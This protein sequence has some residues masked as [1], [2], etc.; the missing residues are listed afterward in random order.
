MEIKK[1]ALCLVSLVSTTTFAHLHEV[2]GVYPAHY[3][4]CEH[5]DFTKDNVEIAF[6]YLELLEAALKSAIEHPNSGYFRKQA[7]NSIVLFNNA[8]Y[9]LFDDRGS[10]FLL[11]DA[12]D[13]VSLK[14]EKF[15]E[16][17]EQKR[18]EQGLNTDGFSIGQLIRLWSD[19]DFVL[20]QLSSQRKLKSKKRPQVNRLNPKRLE[21]FEK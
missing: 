9:D 2:S 12:E 17:Q 4:D 7:E 14:L 3:S 20:Q 13:E 8:K 5:V 21:L 15:R 16:E 1:I 6:E 10:V 11:E 18:W 19:P